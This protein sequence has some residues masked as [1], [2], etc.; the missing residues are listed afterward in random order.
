MGSCGHCQ[1][2]RKHNGRGIPPGAAAQRRQQHAAKIV[3]S[4]EQNA[5]PQIGRFEQNNGAHG[6]NEE[7]IADLHESGSEISAR[8]QID[9][10]HRA[11][12]R[13]GQKDTDEQADTAAAPSFGQAQK[14]D[15]AEGDLFKRADGHA[16]QREPKP[17]SGRAVHDISIAP[18]EG[19]N[20]QIVDD[21][22][23]QPLSI[24]I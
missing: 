7:G 17:V 12:D 6:A 9:S 4:V 10:V 22:Y 3:D 24:F 18:N 2:C 8:E 11:K 16:L 23:I 15:T 1:N 20:G 14:D 13:R 5:Q 21:I 19:Q